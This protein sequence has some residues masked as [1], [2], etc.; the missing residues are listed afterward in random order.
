MD[1]RK[2]AEPAAES[3]A[4]RSDAT[5]EQSAVPALPGRSNS[6]S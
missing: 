2:G 6:T 3:N 4:Q 1:T 5:P